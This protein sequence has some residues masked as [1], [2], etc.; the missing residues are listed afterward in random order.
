[1]IPSF[2]LRQLSPVSHAIA[3][4]EKTM[5]AVIAVLTETNFMATRVRFLKLGFQLTGPTTVDLN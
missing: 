3:V 2:F 5:R 4:R 1:M